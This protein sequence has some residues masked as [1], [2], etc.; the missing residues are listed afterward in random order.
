MGYT[1]G[2]WIMEQASESLDDLSDYTLSF[3]YALAEDHIRRCVVP[4]AR[5]LFYTA[6]EEA[7]NVY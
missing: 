4:S 6:K 1:L 5:E 7:K 3:M 2:D